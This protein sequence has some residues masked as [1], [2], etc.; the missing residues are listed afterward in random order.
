MGK[1]VA[2][3]GDIR[4]K[5]KACQE[6]FIRCVSLPLFSRLD[7]FENRQGE[8]NL[9]DYGLKATGIGRSSLE[10]RVRDR[11]DVPEVICDLLD[12]LAEALEDYLQTGIKL[13]PKP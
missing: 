4:G 8:F 7:W 10:H 3:P 1:R 12:G 9:W 5:T 13:T 6:L 11:P 2:L